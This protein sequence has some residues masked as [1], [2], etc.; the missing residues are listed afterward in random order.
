MFYEGMKSK[1]FKVNRSLT[2]QEVHWRLKQGQRLSYRQRELVDDMSLICIN[3]TFLE[4][5]D[6]YHKD[7]GFLTLVIILLGGVFLTGGIGFLWLFLFG[8]Q[9]P[10]VAFYVL[11]FFIFTSPHILFI[12]LLRLECFTWT[13]YPIRFN[14]EKQVV[15]IT[16]LNGQVET[17]PWQAIYFTLG[18]TASGFTGRFWYLQG[19]ILAEDR[20]TVLDTFSVSVYGPRQEEIKRFW[21]LVRRYMEEKD[22]VKHVADI[23]G[24]LLPIN[25]RKESFGLGLRMLMMPAGFVG[26]LLFPF[27]FLQAVAR[28]L[29]IRS[30][31]M[32][33]WPPEVEA[34]CEIAADDPYDFDSDDA[35]MEWHWHFLYRPV[36]TQKSVTGREW[37]VKDDGRR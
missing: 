10:P 29:S 1:G 32:P 15:H 13:H 37:P 14:R 25:K 8:N 9:S 3:S 5:V 30:S 20:D 4:V 2:S 22:G 23:A 33:V 11:I 36:K 27:I 35:D 16:R 17:Y 18:R 7:R 26:V 31:K 34:Q 21:E 6:A 24:W 12:W 19:H 28:W